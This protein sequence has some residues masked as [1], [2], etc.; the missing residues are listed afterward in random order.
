M[1]RWRIYYG[2][3]TTYSDRDGG[4]EFAPAINV[5]V[6]AR[7]KACPSGFGLMFGKDAYVWRGREWHGVDWLGFMDYIQNHQGWQ[8]ILSGRSIFDEDH[9]AVLARAG[10]E[11]LG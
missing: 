8:K 4:P 1:S 6:I 11:G 7:E 3:G 2:D 10:K 5:Q 9:Q